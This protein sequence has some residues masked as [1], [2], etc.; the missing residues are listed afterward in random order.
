MTILRYIQQKK[1]PT[2][3]SFL[4]WQMKYLKQQVRIDD[5]EGKIYEA[6][7]VSYTTGKQ[8]TEELCAKWREQV[9]EPDFV[10]TYYYNADM[11]QP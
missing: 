2:Q 10:P 11:A 8:K 6:L 3:Q 7:G 9:D 4:R 1:M 5:I